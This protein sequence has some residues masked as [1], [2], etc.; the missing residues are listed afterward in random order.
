VSKPKNDNHP[1]KKKRATA[2]NDNRA[3][4]TTIADALRGLE[5]DDGEID[6][7]PAVDAIADLAAWALDLAAA[8]V[9]DWPE[10]QRRVKNARRFVLARLRGKHLRS[11]PYE[12]VIFTA[13]LLA[14]IFEA[15][16]GL[17]M[18]QVVAVLDRIGL[19]TEVVPLTPRPQ[20]AAPT[21][22]AVPSVPPERRVTP[23][24]V[25][26]QITTTLFRLHAEG[27]LDDDEPDAVPCPGCGHGPQIRNAA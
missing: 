24:E 16:V 27:L 10:G 7:G 18:S 15:E 23:S 17:G 8:D 1:P 3:S 12:D 19:P 4:A 2:A 6:Y 5:L 21:A 20:H 22:R 13:G 26:T 14:R 25:L 11:T 9:A